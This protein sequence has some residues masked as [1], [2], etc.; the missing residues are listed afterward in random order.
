MT[1]TSPKE[2]RT[3]GIARAKE[4]ASEA[5]MAY[6]AVPNHYSRGRPVWLPIVE[7]KE[8]WQAAENRVRLL[9]DEDVLYSKRELQE[10]E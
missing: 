4:E 2:Q 10:N 1:K 9:I 8:K 6:M 5:R 7:A 3:A